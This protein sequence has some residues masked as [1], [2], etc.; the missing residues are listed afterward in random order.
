MWQSSASSLDWFTKKHIVRKSYETIDWLNISFSG[1][2]VNVVDR[3]P[4]S[5]ERSIGT[6]IPMDEGKDGEERIGSFENARKY[7]FVYLLLFIHFSCIS[8]HAIHI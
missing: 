1:T 5:V 4:W 3:T 8:E 7:E 2:I 6:E